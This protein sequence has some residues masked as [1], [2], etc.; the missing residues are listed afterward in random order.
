M[1]SRRITRCNKS[2]QSQRDSYFKDWAGH[3]LVINCDG[4][5]G[6]LLRLS[7]V[8]LVFFESCLCLAALSK[9]VGPPIL[10]FDCY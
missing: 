7:A 4:E 10:N 9:G 2:L 3:F 1:Q 8:G 5:R 6:G